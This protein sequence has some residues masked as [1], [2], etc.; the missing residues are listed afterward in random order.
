MLKNVKL[1]YGNINARAMIPRAILYYKHQPFEDCKISFEEDW[2]A[3]KK[4]GEFEFCQLPMLQ[5][6]GNKYFQSLAI[7]LYLA[8]HFELM[9]SNIEEEYLITSLLC[10]MDDVASK[11]KGLISASAEEK[12]KCEEDFVNT[13]APFYLKIYENRFK[14]F[15]AKYMIGDK[16]TLGDIF[17]TTFLHNIFKNNARKKKFEGVLESYA[18]TLNKHINQISQ[19]ELED[20]FAKGYIHE[21][22]I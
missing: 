15:G 17:V 2:P 20:F 22:T 9:G 10:S 14:K 7:N 13:H 4:S 8:K 1:V 3:M 21:A 16:F 6:D 19:N 11:F 12:Q 18:P 5:I